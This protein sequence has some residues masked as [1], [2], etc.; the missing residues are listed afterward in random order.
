MTATPPDKV[1]SLQARS[2][3][4]P[5]ETRQRLLDAAEA[6]FI[7]SGYEGTS[8]RLVTAHAHANLAAVNYYFGSKEALMQTLL[9]QR[10]DRLNRERLQ[11]LDRCEADGG[12]LDAA[13]V[14]AMLFV[15]AFRLAQEGSVGANFMRLLGRVY[16]DRSPFIRDF[17]QG[18]YRPIFGRY[19]DAFARA[20]PQLGRNELGMRLHFGLIALASILAGEEMGSLASDLRMGE[21]IDDAQLL[22]RLV[23]L[24]AP[25]LT[26]PLDDPTQVAAIARLLELDR[27]HAAT[28]AEPARIP[29]PSGNG[30]MA[31]LAEDRPLP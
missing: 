13:S 4:R 18:H 14:L 20:L 31:W 24:I 8:L 7:E 11:L 6:L 2:R 22:A 12:T 26:T 10:L 1:S 21:A 15:P 27:A 29:P 25:F 9:S 16:S 23:A 19:F 28:R 5:T 30:P 17:L 3:R